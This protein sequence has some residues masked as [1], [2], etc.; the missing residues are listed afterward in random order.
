MKTL[1]IYDEL[2]T[3]YYQASGSVTEPTGLPFLW[4]EIPE[5]KYIISINTSGETPE[6]IFA[7]Y[8]ATPEQQLRAD[9]DY[10]LLLQ[11]V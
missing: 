2:G 10:L 7:D 3:I 1:V 11:E 8:P 6:P 4:V 9:V 5:G